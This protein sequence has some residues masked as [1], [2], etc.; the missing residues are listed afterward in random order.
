MVS[1]RLLRSSMVRVAITAGTLHPKP[2][3]M[4]MKLLPCNPMRCISLSM[5]KAARAI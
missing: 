5:M 4:G 2:M 1:R 3:I